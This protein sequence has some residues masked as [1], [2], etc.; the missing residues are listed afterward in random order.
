MIDF[1]DAKGK[2]IARYDEKNSRLSRSKN[3]GSITE[4]RLSGGVESVH[5]Y[6]IPRD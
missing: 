6:L 1:R 4:I 5:S 2:L 3:H